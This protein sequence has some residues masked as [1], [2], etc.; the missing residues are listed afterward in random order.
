MNNLYGNNFVQKQRA[1]GFKSTIYAMAE[2]VDNSVDAGATN[3]DIIIKTK[4]TFAGLK[5]VLSISEILFL[6]NGKGMTKDRI[7]GCLTFSEGEGRSAS[8]IGAFGVGLPNS[9]ISVCQRTEVYSLDQSNTW[10]HVFLDLNDQK[11]RTEPGYDPSIVK[12][13]PL[14]SLI[15]MPDNCRTIIRWAEIDLIDTS[16]TDILIRRA[17]KLL[18]RIYRYKMGRGINISIASYLEGNTQY[19]TPPVS[20]IPY[21]PLFLTETNNYISPLIWKAA[22]IQDPKGRHKILSE[23]SEFNSVFHYK[24][25]INGCQENATHKA[26]FQKHDDYWDVTYPFKVG[27]KTY[28][29]SIKASFACRGIRTP[30]IGAGGRTDIGQ[31]IGKKMTGDRNDKISSANIFFMRGEREI[32]YGNYGLYKVTDEKQRW[33]TIEIHFDQDLD[34]LMGV[35]NVKQSV[36]FRA[37]QHQEIEDVEVHEDLAIGVQREILWEQMSRVISRAIKKMMKEINQYAQDFKRL[38]ESFLD[39]NDGVR[40]PIPQAET[41]VIQV[42]PKGDAWSKEQKQEVATFL[43]EKF[44]HLPINV[45]NHQ[46]K[47]FAD[48][49]TKTLVLYA[50]NESGFLFELT[51]KRGKLITLINTNHVYYTNIIEPL[52]SNKYLKE[53]AISIE[54]LISAYALEMDI[55]IQD[56]PAKYEQPLEKYLLNLSSRLNEFITD[57]DIK[58]NSE[59]WQERLKTRDSAKNNSDD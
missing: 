7:N 28:N 2:I 11:N 56:N 6:D 47:I 50:P 58:I 38:E 49:L 15:D 1:S 40:T 27:N 19:T 23:K 36:G 33:W 45:I 4:E 37:I 44:M 30:G 22:T 10:N 12:N 24:K 8:R 21:D 39:D 18:G 43:K 48:G 25:F 59:L 9:S 20:I 31:A 53:F 35:S 46:V 16:N 26:L 52:K 57:S 55:L 29:W 41:T 14:D 17:N 32:D 3:I 51:E 54:M 13:P 34:E 42:I 5:S